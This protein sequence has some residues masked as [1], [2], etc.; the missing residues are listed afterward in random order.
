MYSVTK[1]LHEPSSICSR[2]SVKRKRASQR[3]YLWSRC[4]MSAGATGRTLVRSPG[5]SS[6]L[7]A[8]RVSSRFP[9]GRHLLHTD[10]E[11]SQ[12]GRI[13]AGYS[14]RLP[15][16]CR[17][18]ALFALRI[19]YKPRSQPF[20]ASTGKYPT[21]FAVEV[22]DID[23]DLWQHA[24][25]RAG[26]TL[27]LLLNGPDSMIELLVKTIVLAFAM[28]GV[29]VYSTSGELTKAS[30]RSRGPERSGHRS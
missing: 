29:R 15:A 14:K 26:S 24:F 9:P 6:F 10:R 8:T 7:S 18:E 17:R 27:R 5:L 25:D 30:S 20:N 2:T 4:G 22:A 23:V 11:P 1:E 3:T 16:S 21:R 13:S 28:V 12:S 19:F